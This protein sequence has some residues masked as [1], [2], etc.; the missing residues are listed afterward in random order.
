MRSTAPHEWCLGLD[1]GTL[2]RRMI[3]GQA[4]RILREVTAIH[5]KLYSVRRLYR[6]GD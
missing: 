5:R 1:K 3:H 6:L 4:I 2:E